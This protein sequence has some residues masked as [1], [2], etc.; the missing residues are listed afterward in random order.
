MEQALIFKWNFLALIIS[1]LN[2]LTCKPS[3]WWLYVYTSAFYALT[4]VYFSIT[5]DEKLFY[6][7]Q[8]VWA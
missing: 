2:C 8:H 7:S 4:K 5:W 6:S 3:V 1:L